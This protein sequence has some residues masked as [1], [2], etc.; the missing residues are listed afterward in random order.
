MK[1][2]AKVKCAL[3]GKEFY[4]LTIFHLRTHYIYS[5]D[6]YVGIYTPVIH[7]YTKPTLLHMQRLKL[8][9]KKDI[10]NYFWG[11]RRR[12]INDIFIDTK[13]CSTINKLLDGCVRCTKLSV[14]MYENM[15]STTINGVPLKFIL[16]YSLR[17]KLSAHS[18]CLKTTDILDYIK[19]KCT[20][21]GRSM[22]S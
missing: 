5:F 6:E 1:E 4:K 8:I 12:R 3:C 7:P 2:K 22:G 17:R 13:T 16:N 21:Y 20:D 18:E 11:I 19:E 15:S 14:C 10:D 9:A